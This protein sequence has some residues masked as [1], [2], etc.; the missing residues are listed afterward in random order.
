[1][2]YLLFG[3]GGLMAIMGLALL[4]L[5]FSRSPIDELRVGLAIFMIIGGIFVSFKVKKDKPRDSKGRNW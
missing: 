5:A 1:M 3:I 2:Q 4:I